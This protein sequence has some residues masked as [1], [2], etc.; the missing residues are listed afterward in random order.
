VQVYEQNSIDGAVTLT[1]AQLGYDPSSY[2]HH[3]VGVSGLATPASDTWNLEVKPA[4]ATGFYYV[5][6]AIPSSGSYNLDAM[7]IEAIRITFS[8]TVSAAALSV[9]SVTRKA[10]IAV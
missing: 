1:S 5:K 7:K 9:Q 2:T 10:F 8:T 4:G 6:T 3:F